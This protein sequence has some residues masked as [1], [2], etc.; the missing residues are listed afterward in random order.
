M[1][2]SFMPSQF[3]LLRKELQQMASRKRTYL[4]RSL[5]AAVLFISFFFLFANEYWVVGGRR[6][7]V[8]VIDLLGIGRE[9]L[10]QVV[11]IQFMGIYLLFPVLVVGAVADEKE[12]GTLP[13][14]IMSGMRPWE[15]V[16]QK[17]ISRLISMFTL[18]LLALP[19]LALAYALG[20]VARVDVVRATV[21]LMV[22]AVHVGAYALLM[23]CCFQTVVG[24][25][26]GAMAGYA[27]MIGALWS[28]PHPWVEAGLESQFGL[29]VYL[30]SSN[31][32]AGDL[33]VACLPMLVASGLLVGLSCLVLTRRA[34][35]TSPRR[36]W[37]LFQF[38]D[39]WMRRLNRRLAGGVEFG[40]SHADLPGE[41]PVAWRERK[42]LVLTKP[43]YRVRVALA[44]AVPASFIA[45]Q[46]VMTGEEGL[47]TY[48]CLVWAGVALGIAV[49][50]IDLMSSERSRQT[51]DVL[52]ATPL[53]SR[54]IVSQKM[55]S[56]SPLM[57]VVMPLFIV[58]FFLEAFVV[59]NSGVYAGSYNYSGHA[60]QATWVYLVQALAAVV[61]LVWLWGWISFWIGMRIQHRV[62]AVFAAMVLLV[63]W[64]IVP[65]GLASI[66]YLA[67]PH[68]GRMLTLASPVGLIIALE[69]EQIEPME[70]RITLALAAIYLPLF[71]A[72]RHAILDR[73]EL[74]IRR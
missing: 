22:S 65:L 66:A 57:V 42:R 43:E 14:L 30:N 48:L 13:L 33:L 61:I 50:C 49:K 71:L 24:A 41:F 15:I 73:A 53:S 62:R 51:L 52:L 4:V 6:G 21:V 29:T 70:G 72:T 31:S 10:E 59:R 39:R 68:I 26:L 7:N 56:L 35:S 38:L 5:Y 9:L 19:L 28:D 11:W 54:A 34:P 2:R 32:P 23:S 37:A 74:W 55:T 46:A 27:V 67:N 20:G 58:P 45:F 47:S 63:L 1:A 69:F 8:T 60:D 18:L 64:N 40:S 16:L 17:L 25:F 12:R 44:L 36:V 3:G